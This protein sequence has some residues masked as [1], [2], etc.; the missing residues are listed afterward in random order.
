MCH[1]T[2]MAGLSFFQCSQVFAIERK[3]SQYSYLVYTTVLS[4]D[5]WR[6]EGALAFPMLICVFVTM[7][8]Q[9][10]SVVP[11]LAYNHK[12]TLTSLWHMIA[13]C[14]YTK[15]TLIWL[16][17]TN[18]FSWMFSWKVVQFLP[19]IMKVHSGRSMISVCMDLYKCTSVVMIWCRC[20]WHIEA[21]YELIGDRWTHILFV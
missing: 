11:E 4:W 6:Y 7:N 1:N 15:N 16:T 3:T 18:Y 10:W 19:R 17:I 2:T 14:R 9:T 5:H 12:P 21:V 8:I 20:V 13:S